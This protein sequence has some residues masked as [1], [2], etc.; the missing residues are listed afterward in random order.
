[1]SFRDL[2]G[3]L[4]W[5][6]Q[7]TR[8]PEYADALTGAPGGSARRYVAELVPSGVQERKEVLLYLIV[9]T[10]RPERVVETGVW[11][12]WSS[13]AIL[14]ALAR[15]GTGHLTSIDLPTTATGRLNAD[16]TF[17]RA[18]VEV[19]SDTGREVP[20]YLRGRWE[21]NVVASAEE[22]AATLKRIAARGMDMFFHDS[23]HSYQNMLQEFES[24]WTGL[25]DKGVLYSDDVDWNRAMID[26]GR[27]VG[28]TP[29]MFRL[30]PYENSRVGGL[31]K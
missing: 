13:R 24:A 29:K 11:L 28:R 27:S 21:L 16:G 17:D 9:R 8:A 30:Y 2:V 6:Y 19:I 14:T 3:D 22:S 20:E 23:D 31:L 7:R 4:Y 18:H 12:G 1:M 15:N 5:V 10:L 25:R 26:F